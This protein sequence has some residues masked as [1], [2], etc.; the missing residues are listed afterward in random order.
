MGSAYNGGHS[1][2]TNGA[3]RGPGRP[4]SLRRLPIGDRRLGR[5]PNGKENPGCESLCFRCGVFDE[6]SFESKVFVSDVGCSKKLLSNS[7]FAFPLGLCL[8][9]R[10]LVGNQRGHP[11]ATTRPMSLRWLPMGGRRRG[12]NPN[13]NDN[14]E[15]ERN[16]IG[17]PVQTAKSFHM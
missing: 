15:S 7:R 6:T 8:Q 10:P 5:N 4:M 16:F 11:G 9:R 12:Q 1:L 14:R 13:K 2:K 3:S 17:L